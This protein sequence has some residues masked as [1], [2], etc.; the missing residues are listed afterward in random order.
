[1]KPLTIFEYAVLF[2]ILAIVI[3]FS[4]K[5]VIITQEI[6]R[7]NK[8]IIE[9]SEQI[10]IITL[11][12]KEFEDQIS[13]LQ[14]MTENNTKSLDTTAKAFKHIS[15]ILKVHNGTLNMHKESFQNII[16]ILGNNRY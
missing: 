5:D 4:Y 12:N 7:Y 9:L 2:V 16:N 8:K 11:K 1:M 14:I 3:I 6:E 15:T 13:A 10:E